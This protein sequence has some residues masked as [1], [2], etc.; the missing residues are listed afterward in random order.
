MHESKKYYAR[1]EILEGDYA[2]K[3]KKI[4]RRK[5]VV[6][7]PSE[8]PKVSL[9][10]VGINRRLTIAGRYSG[11]AADAL[12]EAVA[13]M[14]LRFP[15]A[16]TIMYASFRKNAE[17]IFKNHPR[18]VKKGRC[19][20]YNFNGELIYIKLMKVEIPKS[21]TIKINRVP[22]AEI[23]ECFFKALVRKTEPSAPFTLQWV[24]KW[25]D[26]GKNE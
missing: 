19:F 10:D 4:K 8:P 2:M 7:G 26:E 21:K 9:D 18:V 16:K 22:N 1:Q 25:K 23:D 17:Q 13:I 5:I 3:R 6:V 12:D 15:A 11:K 14:K 24:T 20:Y